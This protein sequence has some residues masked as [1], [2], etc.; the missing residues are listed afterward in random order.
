[1]SNLIININDQVRKKRLL[2]LSIFLN[3]FYLG[4]FK[5]TDFIIQNINTLIGSDIEK[6]NIPF[7]LAM[8][9]FTFQTIAFLVD[10][11]DE[12]IKKNDLKKYSLFIIFFPQLVAGPIVKYNDMIPQFE[13]PKNQLINKN[14]IVLGLFVI[15]IGLFK[16]IVI[17]DTLSINVDD[18]FNNYL[19]LNFV[20]SW[21]ISLS[22]TLQI[23]FDFS[24]YI[25]MAT[26]SAILFNIRLP[27][28]FDS[29]FKASSLINFWHRWHIT[30]FKFL[31]N[32]IYFPWIRSLK[33]ITYSKA[34]FV[35][36]CV[37]IISGIWHGPTWGYVMFGILHG[38]GLII[39]H[40]FIRLNLFKIPSFVGWFL[41]M[42]WVNLTQIFFRS[43][44]LDTAIYISKSIFGLNGFEFK[45]NLLNDYLILSASITAL[46]IVFCFKNTNYLIENH[47]KNNNS[48]I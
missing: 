28:N 43:K 22:F 47:F 30:L 8:S 10:C 18:G 33:K 15:I 32:Y 19:E 46:I 35:T 40:T 4:I 36:F 42:F 5:Y 2:L 24:G 20:E 14:N 9:F 26:G 37:F 13:N 34:M 12:E 17:A 27:Q 11:Y 31:M 1:M 44:D 16:K 7:P 23:Y 48:K 3:V 25:D 6:F 29:P 41:T 39:N 45:T 38:V 21:I